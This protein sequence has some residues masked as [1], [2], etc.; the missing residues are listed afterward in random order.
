[1]LKEKRI[2]CVGHST[3]YTENSQDHKNMTQQSMVFEWKLHQTYE[4]SMHG[5]IMT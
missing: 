2:Y 3:K 1:M 5:S 4:V